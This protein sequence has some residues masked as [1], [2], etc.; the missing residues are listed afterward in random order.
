MRTH[1]TTYRHCAIEIIEPTNPYAPCAFT[2]NGHGES[3]DQRYT[4]HMQRSA[5][6]LLEFLK[7]NI[8]LRADGEI[9]GLT[10]MAH[11]YAPGTWEVCPASAGAAY[12][13]HIKPVDGPCNESP[14]KKAAAKKARSERR[15]AEGHPSVAAISARLAKKF[16]RRGRRPNA[17]F[18]VM[19]NDSCDYRKGVRV[20]WYREGGNMPLS[21]HP[22]QLP[23]IFEELRGVD[24]WSVDY[25][26][27][28]VV[29]VISRTAGIR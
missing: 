29:N 7:M 1:R 8:D 22:G 14:C 23:Q 27:G 25:D 13:E 6:E 10:N 2:I 4:D 19:A 16:P 18:A 26:G 21:T 9:M 24:R 12:N 15:R 17:G 5:A 3:R 28:A 11:W 20:V